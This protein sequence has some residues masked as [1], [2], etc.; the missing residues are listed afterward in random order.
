MKKKTKSSKEAKAL[1]VTTTPQEIRKAEPFAWTDEQID[2]VK[3]TVAKD[4]TDDELKLFLYTAKRTGLDP[5][6]RQIHFV[7]RKSYNKLTR[8]YTENMTIQTGID[9]YR[10][11]AERTGELAGI[12]DAIFDG[13]SPTDAHPIKATVNVYR[14]VQGQ[15]VAFTASARWDEYAALDKEGNPSFMWKKMP[16]LMLAKCAESLA[17][18]KAFPNDLTG[19][20][21]NEEMAQADTKT[22]GGATTLPKPPQTF[23]VGQDKPLKSGIKIETEVN[24]LKKSIFA[25]LKILKP[26]VTKDSVAVFVKELTG[27]DLVEANY[28]EIDAQ[29]LIKASQN[30]TK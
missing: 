19:L 30:E 24:N 4:A 15:R 20:Y 8:S 22:E 7:K 3:K 14:M 16:Y 6:T 5:L 26:E 9:G 11:I 2:L 12:D 1:V 27:L 10:A 18:R 29:L 17:L 21:T 13:D 23:N 25:S 28:V